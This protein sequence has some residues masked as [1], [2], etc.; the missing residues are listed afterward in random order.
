MTLKDNQLP[1]PYVA[2]ATLW[3]H[4]RGEQKQGTLAFLPPH[5]VLASLVT[6]DTVNE[7]CSVSTIQAPISDLLSETC[8]RIGA[9][10]TDNMAALS[11]WGDR[12]NYH[13]RDGVYL[14]LFSVLTGVHSKR[15]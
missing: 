2:S 1:E 3:D 9:T 13:T 11:V 8:R 10:R 14:F 7:W 15:F 4:K 5:E 12:A 6:E